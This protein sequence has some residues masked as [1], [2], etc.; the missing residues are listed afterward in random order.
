MRRPRPILIAAVVLMLLSWRVL[1]Q[2]PSAPDAAIT[3]QTA[4]S[5]AVVVYLPAAP[6]ESA[7]RLAGAITDLG[8]YLGRQMSGLTLD[9]RAFRRAEDVA[10]F[11]QESG[12]EIALLVADAALVHDLPPGVRILPLYRFVARRS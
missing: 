1:A 4:R 7:S 11:L 5:A 8:H 2:G 10:G 9:V 12:N 6:V 3:S